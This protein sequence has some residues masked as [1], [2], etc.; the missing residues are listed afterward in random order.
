MREAVKT[1][2]LYLVLSHTLAKSVCDISVPQEA[3]TFFLHEL[4]IPSRMVG[5]TLAVINIYIIFLL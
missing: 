2:C 4:L 1:K 5:E 3:I